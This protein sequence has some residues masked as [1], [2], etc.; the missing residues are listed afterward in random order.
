MAPPPCFQSY[1][2][3]LQEIQA[4]EKSVTTETETIATLKNY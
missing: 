4:T 3:R 1:P 2:Q